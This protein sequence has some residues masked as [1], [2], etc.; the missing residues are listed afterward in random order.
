MRA[1]SLRR[2][3]G[4]I[5]NTFSYTASRITNKIRPNHL[6][7]SFFREPGYLAIAKLRKNTVLYGTP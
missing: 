7:C 3:A 4:A 1:D 2:K 5:T 6:E